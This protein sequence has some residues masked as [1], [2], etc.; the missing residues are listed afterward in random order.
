MGDVSYILELKASLRRPSVKEY[1][2]LLNNNYIKCK[3]IYVVGELSFMI[4]AR[5]NKG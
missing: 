1:F 5:T 3:R 4:H 2:A